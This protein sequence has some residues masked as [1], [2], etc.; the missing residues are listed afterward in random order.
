MRLTRVV[1]G[2]SLL[3]LVAAVSGGCSTMFRGSSQSVR[4]VTEPANATVVIDKT[5]YRAPVEVELRRADKHEVTVSAP[6][7]Q[8]IKFA[9]EG[10]IDAVTLSQVALPG[11]SVLVGADVASGAGMSYN[12]LAKIRLVPAEHPTTQPVR[13]YEWRGDLLTWGELNE[14]KAALDQHRRE[15]MLGPKIHR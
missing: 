9:F 7:Y 10:K 5:T 8:P 3:S 13:L 11:G 6:G 4:F 1:F 15:A 12:K 2:A 14:H